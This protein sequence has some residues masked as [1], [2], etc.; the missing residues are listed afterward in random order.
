MLSK[1]FNYK[2]LCRKQRSAEL[3]TPLSKLSELLLFRNK[4]FF[5]FR[6]KALIKRVIFMSL[7]PVM[8]VQN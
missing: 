1:N 4:R 7:F 8:D 3:V 5:D 6:D 2:M